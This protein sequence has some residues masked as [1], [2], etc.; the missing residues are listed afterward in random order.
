MYYYLHDTFLAD[1]RW[2]KVVDRIKTRL[3]DLEIGGKHEK[4]TLLKSV[5]ELIGDEVKRGMTTVVVIGNDKTFL[6]VVDVAAK[7][8]ITVGLIPVGPENNLAQYLGLPMAEAACDVLAARKI[9]AMD[10]GRVANQY[11]FTSLKIN[12]N[13]DRLSVQKDSY[14]I[15]PQAGCAEIAIYNFYFPFGDEQFSRKM[16]IN[17]AQD[18]RMELVIKTKAKSKGWSPFGK[19]AHDLKIDSIIQGQKFDVKSF[20]YLPVKLDEFKVLKTP[21]V[22]EVEKNKLNVIVGKNRAK[23]IV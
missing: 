18:G 17:S 6:K 22:V 16:R 5:D 21:I 2:E 19:K 7:S 12:K 23:H 14:K 15:V 20:E 1:K 13:L 3:L 9:V 4:L 11:F 10:L 8:N